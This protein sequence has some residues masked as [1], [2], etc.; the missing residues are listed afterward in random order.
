MSIIVRDMEVNE[1]AEVYKIGKRA[2]TG[3]ES[4]FVG[5]PKLALVAVKDEK[6]VGAILY[7][8]FQCDGKKIGYVDYAF[9]DPDYHNQGV[10]G[11]LYKAATDFLWWLSSRWQCLYRFLFCNSDRLSNY[12]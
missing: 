12:K 10:G 2:F 7:K 9:I 1:A 8:F 6:I 5:K 4:L 11:I 3:L